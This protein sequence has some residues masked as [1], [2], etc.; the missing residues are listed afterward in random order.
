MIIIYYLTILCLKTLS[1]L[2]KEDLQK[3]FL[4]KINFI[5]SKEHGKFFHEGQ[6][7]FC[8]VLSLTLTNRQTKE[9]KETKKTTTTENPEIKRCTEGV[10]EWEK[11]Q[12]QR[13]RQ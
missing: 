9:G 8:F 13:D 11:K 5:N 4:K 7:C 10:G 6:M 3:A 1:A 12:E 2:Y